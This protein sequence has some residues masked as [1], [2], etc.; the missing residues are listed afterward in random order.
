MCVCVCVNTHNTQID[1]IAKVFFKIIFNKKY[2]IIIFMLILEE[3]LIL[4]N[5]MLLICL[6]YQIEM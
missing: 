6:E 2:L 4:K 1:Y 5:E 3:F